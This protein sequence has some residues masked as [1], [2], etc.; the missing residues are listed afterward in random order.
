MVS[1][2]LRYFPVTICLFD[3]PSPKSDFGRDSS[4]IYKVDSG[5]TVFFGQ[6]FPTPVRSVGLPCRLRFR[7]C[8]LLKSHHHLV[9]PPVTPK[10]TSLVLYSTLPQPLNLPPI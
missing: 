10:L 8:P 6:F 1:H 5:R 4:T 3:S 9:F 2:Y 7:D